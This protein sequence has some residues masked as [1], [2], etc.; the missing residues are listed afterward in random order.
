MEPVPVPEPVPEVT[1]ILLAAGFSRRFGSAKLLKKLP[2]GIPVCIAAARALK[3]Q[4]PNV[5]AVIRKDDDSLKAAFEEMSL[6]VVEN[7]RA[8]Q[9]MGTSLAAGV[10]AT[11]D[12]AGW[13]I[14][15][16]D[17]P[18]IEPAT[19]GMLTEQLQQGASIVAP[20]YQGDRGHPVGFAHRWGQQLASLKDDRGASRLLDQY[21]NELVLL[22]TQDPGVLKDVDFPED[23]ES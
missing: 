22:D 23:M 11:A 10:N 18:W 20:V 9:G 4:V 6:Q 5:V 8:D 16:A 17:M 3:Q 2:D 21:V 12:S 7:P 1:A 19:I 15:L 13:L 14:A